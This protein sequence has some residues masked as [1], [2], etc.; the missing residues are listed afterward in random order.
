VPG[1]GPDDEDDVIRAVLLDFYGTVVADDDSIVDAICEE[2]RIACPEP[3]RVRSHEVGDFWWRLFCQEAGDSTA[4]TFRLQRDMAVSSLADTVRHFGSMANPHDLCERQFMYWRQPELF[5]DTRSFL[6]TVG[7]PVCIV[8][9]IDRPDVEAAINHHRLPLAMVLTS[10]DVRCYK[11]GAA[12]FERS[13]QLL[14]LR[15]DEVVH[16]GNSLSADI[17]GAHGAGIPAIW[18]N[19]SGRARPDPFTAIADVPTLSEALPVLQRIRA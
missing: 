13:L 19:R 11:P 16:I 18:I 14:G 12:I 7:L 3:D 17:A 4:S 9:D 10:E 2:V 6:G 15:S 8:S 1:V 5:P